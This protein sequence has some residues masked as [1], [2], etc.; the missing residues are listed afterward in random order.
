MGA[1]KLKGAGAF[2]L[3]GGYGEEEPFVSE[4]ILA[5]G[6][7]AAASVAAEGAEP[8][9][10][11]VFASSGGYEDGAFVL[12]GVDN[13]LAFDGASVLAPKLNGVGAVAFNGACA[14]EEDLLAAADGSL[15]LA[16][17]GFDS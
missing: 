9:G 13:S 16:A 1:A 10:S 11:G 8:N 7:P 12:D 3:S 6:A 17:A 5:F 14:E 4:A 15:D 2:R